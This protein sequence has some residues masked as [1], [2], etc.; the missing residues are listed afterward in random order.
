MT[1]CWHAFDKIM[2]VSIDGNSDRR[3]LAQNFFKKHNVPVEFMNVPKQ[4]RGED[5]SRFDGHIL[6]MRA[7]LKD[8]ELQNLLLFDDNPEILQLPNAEGVK[9]V[10]QFIEYRNFDILALDA[11]P[12]ILF[13]LPESV[14]NFKYLFKTHTQSAS[15]YVISRKFME[16]MVKMD[17]DL[18]HASLGEL[19]SVNNNTFATLP[20]WFGQA[21]DPR[22][23]HSS[24]AQI[25]DIWQK[26][27]AH[28]R[29]WYGANSKFPAIVAVLIAIL[30]VV[31]LVI[32]FR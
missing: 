5:V 3:N 20:A 6:A 1:N 27:N 29:G 17:F 15:A 25:R 11:T 26:T 28:V 10:C 2:C 13:D 21:I 14:P 4:Q 30:V 18:M 9:E 24:T 12:A 16:R 22:L 19:Y 31:L 8:P 32:L 7:A 23:V